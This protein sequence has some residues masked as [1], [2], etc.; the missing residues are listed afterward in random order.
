MRLSDGP[1]PRLPFA[2]GGL[3]SGWELAGCG[4]MM[5]VSKLSEEA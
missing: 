3:G 4:I 1:S 5:T 2:P